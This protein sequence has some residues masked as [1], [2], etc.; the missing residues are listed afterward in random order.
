[1]VGGLGPQ[2]TFQTNDLCCK[3]VLGWTQ[4]CQMIY[5][6]LVLINGVD[7]GNIYFFQSIEFAET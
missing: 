2:S 7:V 1:M 3:K 4:D 6:L 5:S